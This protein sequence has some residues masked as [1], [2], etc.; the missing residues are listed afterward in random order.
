[1][2]VGQMA[3]YL[4]RGR[5]NWLF[6]N[7]L[8]C[9]VTTEKK[10]TRAELLAWCREKHAQGHTLELCWDGGNDNGWCWLEINESQ[11]LAPEDEPYANALTDLMDDELD[12][13]SWAGDFSANGRA[14]FYPEE[15]CFQGTDYYSESS[16]DSVEIEKSLL[17]P[18]ELPFES[19]TIQIDSEGSVL[20]DSVSVVFHLQNGFFTPDHKKVVR[21]LKN[22]VA[23]LVDTA[24]EEAIENDALE[25]DYTRCWNQLRF[26]A[27]EMTPTSSGK[28]LKLFLDSVD[29]NVQKE[30]PKDIYLDLSEV[31]E[32][33][34]L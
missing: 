11:K 26:E 14:P 28:S 20:K 34:D 13:G 1:M 21:K 27:S 12:Y 19:V 31:E 17:I 2:P 4:P 29:V 8:I 7:H 15:G 3:S 25:G 30:F 5:E 24:V 23:D 16:E 10:F 22:R 33:E 6:S 9:M 18:A 32:D